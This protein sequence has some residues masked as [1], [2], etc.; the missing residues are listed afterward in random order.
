MH[1]KFPESYYKRVITELLSQSEQLKS[2]ANPE[3]VLEDTLKMLSQLLH[4]NR[5]RILL[6][7]ESLESLKIKYS[8]KLSREE[9]NKGKYAICEGITGQVFDS[10]KAALISNVMTESNYLGKVTPRH[11]SDQQP[12]S[13]IA[14]PIAYEGNLYGVLAVESITHY[15]GDVEANG[16]VLQLV[17]EMLANIIHTY[18]LCDFN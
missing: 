18:S 5:G 15:D 14:V 8:Y 4:L 9:V 6:W 12:L 10:G 16:L 7:D 1:K 3:L 2:S 13:Y 11:L 17:A